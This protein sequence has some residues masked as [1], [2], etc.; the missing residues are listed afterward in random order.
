M[1]KR[2]T[3]AKSE[4]EIA[5]I[6]WDL[7]EATVRQVA[8]TLP[9]EREID[10]W[11]V[12]TY[13]RRLTAKGYLRKRREGRNNLYSP[14]V[15]PRTVVHEVVDDLINRLF[16]GQALPL[17]QHLISERGLSEQEVEQLQKSLDEMKVR[18]K[19][20]RNERSG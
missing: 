19:G 12:Q 6:V 18:K 15:R 10:F 17:F 11:T 13:L 16:D 5:R 9:A 20:R 3:L 2:P 14:S 4:L 8:D 7:G 1:A